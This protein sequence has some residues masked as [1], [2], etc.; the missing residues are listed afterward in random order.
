MKCETFS[1]SVRVSQSWAEPVPVVATKRPSG[2]WSR[3]PGPPRPAAS[4]APAVFSGA[5]G[6][7]DLSAYAHFVCC[8]CCV[9]PRTRFP[10]G[11]LRPAAHESFVE[12]HRHPARPPARRL[13]GRPDLRWPPRTTTCP[14]FH[15]V[16][17]IRGVAG[18][19]SEGR[20]ENASPRRQGKKVLLVHDDVT[21]TVVLNGV[22]LRFRT[23][24][25]ENPRLRSTPSSPL[26]SRHR[27]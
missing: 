9:F 27:S 14:G 24:V 13:E 21:P 25:S 12:G 7:S 17:L 22:V 15:P 4:A 11:P 8:V 2:A 16:V 20:L 19:S 5:F 23:S 18:G 10:G 1:A 3:R 26:P 6:A